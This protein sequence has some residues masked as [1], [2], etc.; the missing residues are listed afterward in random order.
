MRVPRE[1]ERGAFLSWGRTGDTKERA[2]VRFCLGDSGVRVKVRWEY[3]VK[4]RFR[5]DVEDGV[6]GLVDV[7]HVFVEFL[8]VALGAPTRK[9]SHLCKLS[10][11]LFWSW[12]HK[13][14][15]RFLRRRYLVTMESVSEEPQDGDRASRLRY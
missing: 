7:L 3:E 2:R 10:L 14:H 15:T 4:D 13:A 1:I 8:L 5:E 9:I 12:R 11:S 6:A